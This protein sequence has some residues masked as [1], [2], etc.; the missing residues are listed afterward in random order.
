[1]QS[2]GG[3]RYL[4]VGL[5]NPGRAH[6]YN[7]HNI[8]F[9]ALDRLAT[10]HGIELKRVQNKAIVG[11]G[12][13]A[14]RSVIL[15]KPQTFMN[16]SGQAVGPLANFYKIPPANTLVAYDEL[17]IPFGVIRLRE[18]GGA[19]G[20]N[21]MR[22]IIQ[23]LGQEFPR[24][25]LGIGRPPGR[26][27]AAGFVLQDFGRDELPLVSEMLDTA[28][29]AVESFVTNGIDL[30]MSRFNGPVGVQPEK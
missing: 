27:D 18:K 16:L 20:H 10:R 11:V 13:V 8:G 17:D 14:G 29:A 2:G 12:R 4:I 30:T 19:G 7:R 1:M 15:A 28:L 25:R 5:G 3:E 22:S 24:L 26:M 9:M 23:H 21:G 6:L